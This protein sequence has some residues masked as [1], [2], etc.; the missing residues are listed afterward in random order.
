MASDSGMSNQ[1]ASAIGT[2]CDVPSSNEMTPAVSSE[3][4]DELMMAQQFHVIEHAYDALARQLEYYFSPQ[5]LQS[6]TY[7]QTLREL[8]DGC[9]PVSIL[10][11]FTKV[12][13][14]LASLNGF[15]TVQSMQKRSNPKQR[16]LEEEMQ[17]IHAI[18]HVVNTCYTYNLQIF[19]IDTQTGK[20]SASS[21][22]SSLPSN[23]VLAVGFQSLSAPSEDL[24]DATTVDGSNILVLRYVPD[25]VTE[26]EIR[27][28]LGT[29]SDC[30]T[31]LSV[32]PD[33]AGCWYV[34]F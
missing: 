21:K 31:I 6:D 20:I 7:L 18:V 4:L 12:K 24:E 34:F 30:P 14:I 33:V 27:T 23:I 1:N 28:L 5:N 11:N 16:F 13:A 9:V 25:M 17:R 22:A 26:Q 19:S 15:E 10:A 2:E 3:V 32:V 8:N 29:I